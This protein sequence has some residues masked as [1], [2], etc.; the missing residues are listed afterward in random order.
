MKT[1][2]LLLVLCY[3]G[4]VWRVGGLYWLMPRNG[5]KC[6]IEEVPRETLVVITYD[7]LDFDA[8][9]NRKMVSSIK[10]PFDLVLVEQEVH[11]KT[12]R[13]AFSSEHSGDHRVCFRIPS[14]G[15]REEIRV[16]IHMDS[17]DHAHDYDKLAR[18]EHLSTVEVELRRLNDKIKTIRNEQTYQKRRE[19]EF[20]NTS[21]ATNTK[22]VWWSLFQTSILICCGIFQ[23]WHLRKFFASKKLV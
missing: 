9:G 11:D 6:F 3:V 17:G 15:A 18:V 12:G 7:I 13:I 4:C 21:E 22:V 8:L 19:E 2:L 23:I 10:D 1:T 16:E 20:R 14:I 5:E